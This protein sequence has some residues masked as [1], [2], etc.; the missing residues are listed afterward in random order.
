[1]SEGSDADAE[2][3]C[4]TRSRLASREVEWMWFNDAPGPRGGGDRGPYLRLADRWKAAA[5]E[6][7]MGRTGVLREEERGGTIGASVEMEAV[8]ED[9]PAFTRFSSPPAAVCSIT[10]GVG[11]PT[12][13]GSDAALLGMGRVV[14]GA[15]K[16]VIVSLCERVARGRFEGVVGSRR[17]REAER[18]SNCCSSPLN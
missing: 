8:G 4:C 14:G 2:E 5:L 15:D 3:R 18:E 6:P 11:V 7:D 16:G 12:S 17:S 10:A 9:G 13:V 1:M